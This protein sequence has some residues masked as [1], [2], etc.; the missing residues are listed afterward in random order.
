MKPNNKINPGTIF[1][2]FLPGSDE[3][4]IIRLVKI[5]NSDCFIVMSK[6]V[7]VKMTATEFYTYTKL[8]PDA[9]ICFSI[10]ELEGEVPD[11]LIS[12]YRK[13]DAETD[14]I[15]Y[16]ICRQSI[17]DLYTNTVSP[18]E[19][20]RFYIG[21]SV[22]KDT[23]PAD[24]NFKQLLACNG[25]VK[26]DIVSAYYDDSLST[27]LSFVNTMDYDNALK[28]LYEGYDHT[29]VIT[30]CTSL[31]TLLT[32]S[33][34]MEDFWRGL[35]VVKAPYEFIPELATELLHWV[36]DVIKH[37]MIS[38]VVVKFTRDIN[39]AAIQDDYV[40][41]LD[42]KDNIFVISY[43]RGEY[44]NRPYVELGDDTELKA[45]ETAT[46]K[47]YGKFHVVK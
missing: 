43:K 28:L 14:G 29:K 13:E 34:F 38:P 47:E 37:E 41:L 25:V 8:N 10:L 22:S 30:E 5:Q 23:C 2:R 11:V 4:N 45:L 27:I 16:C 3:P 31:E 6:G 12:I 36:E 40:L 1:F 32:S 20:G 21:C 9:Q 26:T 42:A 24:V 19:D 15:P 18:S 33:H 44:I 39:L 7:K 17:Y 46:G 35:N